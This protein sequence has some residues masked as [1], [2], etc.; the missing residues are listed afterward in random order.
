MLVDGTRTI[1]QLV[2]D[3]NTALARASGDA[4]MPAVTRQTVEDNLG[5]LAKLGLLVAGTA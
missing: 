1:D 5:L 3:L 2:A 4:P